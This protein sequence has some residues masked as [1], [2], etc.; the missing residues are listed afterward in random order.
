[1][2]KAIYVG[3]RQLEI[4]GNHPA[5]AR[6]AGEAGVLATRIELGSQ[7]REVV[8]QNIADLSIAAALVEEASAGIEAEI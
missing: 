7:R 1:M 3:P 2:A 5:V 6:V 8:A 4:A